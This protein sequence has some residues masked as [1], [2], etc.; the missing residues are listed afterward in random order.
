MCG[1]GTFGHPPD[2]LKKEYREYTD[3]EEEPESSEMCFDL[4][5]EMRLRPGTRKRPTGKDE[6]TIPQNI[7]LIDEFG[8]QGDKKRS[9]DF[10]GFVI[11]I[12]DRKKEMESI[13]QEVRGKKAELKSRDATGFE[14]DWAITRIARL[15]PETYGVYVDKRKNDHPDIWEGSDRAAAYRRV[16]KA[17]V[18]DALKRT[19]KDDFLVLVDYTTALEKGGHDTIMEAVKEVAD[20]TGTQKKKIM[21][22]EEVDSKDCDIM[23]AHDF[24]TGALRDSVLGIDDRWMNQLSMK[25]K[26]LRKR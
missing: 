10:L 11:T 5:L 24:V 1:E 23:Q 20:E 25:F 19:V 26:R 22:Y 8:D 13:A 14:K 9:S 15:K 4:I 12:T 3:M 2:I 16:M 6:K 18:K 7:M 17:A 21:S